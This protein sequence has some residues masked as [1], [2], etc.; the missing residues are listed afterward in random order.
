MIPIPSPLRRLLL[1]AT[2]ALLTICAAARAQL[3]SENF[4]SGAANFTVVSGGTWSVTSGKYVL[5]N[6]VNGPAG[7]GNGNISTHNTSVSGDFTLTV[8][9]S[10]TATSALWNDFSV[11]FNYQN[12]TNY[13]WV[14]FN[15]SNDGGTSGLFKIVNGVQTQLADITSLITAGTTYAVKIE[16]TGS[17]YRAYRNNVLLATATDTAFTSGKVGFGTLNDGAS[18]DNLVVTL[19]GLPPTAA[20]SFSPVAGTYTSAQNVTITSATSGATIRFTTD[21]STPSTTVGTVYSSPVAIGSTTTLKAI[22]YKSGN[23]NSTVTTGVYTINLPAAG[24]FYV[25]PATGSM[26]NPGTSSSPWSTLEA[27]FAAGKTF[28]PGDIIH[29]RTGYHGFP[30]VAGHNADDVTIQA[31][32]G[33]TPRARK[34]A[35]NN[36]SNWVVRDLDICPLHAGASS[37]DTGTHVNIP[38]NSSDIAVLNCRVRSAFSITGWLD[39]DW[40]GRTGKAFGVAGP[41]STITGNIMENVKWGVD[42]SKTAVN[43][44]VSTNSITNIMSDGFRGLANNCTFEYN[45]LRNMF[46]IDGNHDDAFQSWSTDANGTVGAGTVTGVIVRGNTF[47]SYTDP[48]QPY[49][50]TMQGIG[51]FDGMFQDWVVENNL[52]VTDQWHG[53]AFYGAVNCRIV[54]NTVVKNPINARTNTPWIQ[55]FAHKNGTPSTGNNVRNN[56]GSDINSGANGNWSNNIETQAYTTFFVNYAGFDFHLKSGAPAIGAGTT[57]NAPTIDLDKKARTVPYDVGAYEF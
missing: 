42:V 47:I 49:K 43:S 46:S 48:N 23:A 34:L 3:I 32:S 31:Q 57:T 29:L 55:I 44:L 6:P 39:T 26:S 35:F 19:P 27:V 4:T 54:N 33:H 14:S 11:L 20:P 1:G 28:S 2:L 9:A 45:I 41:R 53:I 5:T 56:L 50:A 36:A 16:R 13:Y 25:D 37:Y 17:T 8:D 18:Y 51:N 22:A 52:V 40:P 10:A 38:S 30:T 21:G 7:S 15:E 24:N 12:S